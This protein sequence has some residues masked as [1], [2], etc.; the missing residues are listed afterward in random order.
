MAS[1]S[2]RLAYIKVINLDKARAMGV[3]IPS[4]IKLPEGVKFYALHA[5]D[6]TALGITDTWDSAYAAAVQNDFLLLSVH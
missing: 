1:G 6:G 4:E 5:A 3:E 2:A